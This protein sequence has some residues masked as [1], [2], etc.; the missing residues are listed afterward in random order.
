VSQHVRPSEARLARNEHRRLNRVNEAIAIE[1]IAME[2]G[3]RGVRAELEKDNSLLSGYNP[4]MRE[5]HERNADRLTQ[6]IAQIG[7]PSPSMVG[8]DAARAAFLIVQ[9]AISRPAFMR[10][11]LPLIERAAQRGELPRIEVAMLTDRIL[12]LSGK[13]QLYGTQFDWDESGQMSPRPRENV[14][15]ADRLR[16]DAGMETLAENIARIRH[17][18]GPSEKAPA[19]WKRQQQRAKEFA[20]SVGWRD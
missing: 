7:W 8:E 4:R 11:C 17:R 9:H 18:I 15:E 10:S 3:D 5:V 19:D 13:P 12:I 2:A 16:K 6:V 1:V 14:E 20:K